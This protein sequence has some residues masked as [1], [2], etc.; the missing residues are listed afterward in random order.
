MLGLL[1][2]PTAGAVLRW[3]RTLLDPGRSGRPSYAD[4]DALA[5]EVA[6]GSGGLLTL[7][8]FGGADGPSRGALLGLSLS[9][10]QAH[11]WRSLLEATSYAL[12]DLVDAFTAAG[13]AV[14]ELRSSGGGSRSALWQSIAA[15]VCGVPV[16]P[17]FG[18]AASAGAALLGAWGAGLV[19]T[20]VD[21]RPLATGELHRPGTTAEYSGLTLGY[22][23]AV[24]ALDPFW[25][26]RT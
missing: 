18:E 24:A 10:D 4:L 11:L 19:P 16:R 2:E 15:D 5:A 9:S 26:A 7:P 20:G 3:F 23:A 6:P 25:A 13:T 14:T 8:A 1:F 12:R 22:R 17:P 21:P